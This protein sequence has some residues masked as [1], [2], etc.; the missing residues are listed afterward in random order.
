MKKDENNPGEAR[1]ACLFRFIDFRS[2]E[3][4]VGSMHFL[5]YMDIFDEKYLP[6]L[7]VLLIV[8]M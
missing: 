3:W 6:V 2:M 4:I 7:Y 8:K 1:K 5:S